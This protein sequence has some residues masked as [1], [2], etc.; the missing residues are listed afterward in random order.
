[1]AVL[2]P[3]AFA[4]EAA[5]LWNSDDLERAIRNGEMVLHYQPKIDLRTHRVTAVEAL[6]RWQRPGGPL[7]FPDAFIPLVEESE[8]MPTLTGDVL[9]QA[10]DQYMS[11]RDAGI[12][13]T[14]AV[15]VAASLL[16]DPRGVPHVARA[17]ATRSIS[18]AALTL[19]VTESVVM[20]D[21]DSA[22][23]TLRSL[24]RM[25][26]TVSVDDFGTGYSSL[27]YLSQMPVRELK[28]DRSFVMG[29]P[30]SENNQAIV[31]SILGLGHGFGHH[32][33]AEGV[34]DL[35]TYVMLQRAGC[36]MA[37]GY[38]V[39]R[40]I[41]SRDFARWL[42][43]EWPARAAT[44]ARASVIDM[45]DDEGSLVLDD[46][47]DMQVAHLRAYEGL[48][49]AGN[50]GAVVDA[51]RAY[52]VAVGGRLGDADDDD[53][54]EVVPIDISLG[55]GEPL[56]PLAAVA[57]RARRQLDKTLPRMVADGRRLA[58]LVRAGAS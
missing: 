58:A 17:L 20:S 22:L 1:M 31:R 29:M 55:E 6:V 52:V 53:V 19:E 37:Q 46:E 43:D 10:L 44:L 49:A 18:P 32:V 12:H 40:P 9:A 21:V 8:L 35:A 42:L 11:W 26:I 16:A 30:T 56:L 50:A 33:V 36:D 27:A 28:I 3:P 25:G 5:G 34:E 14:V 51:L 2:I 24:D 15:N 41:P 7:V 4:T 48:V 57:S 45:S 54:M 38:F 47:R 23:S 39:S 13:I